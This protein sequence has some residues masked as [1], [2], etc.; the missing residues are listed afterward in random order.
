MQQGIALSYSL[1]VLSEK[2]AATVA[3]AVDHKIPSNSNKSKISIGLKL[4]LKYVSK[5]PKSDKKKIKI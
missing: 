1:Y 2:I 3:L 5:I 4:F